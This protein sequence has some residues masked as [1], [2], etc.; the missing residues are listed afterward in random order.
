[1][2]A[3]RVVLLK[4]LQPSQCPLGMLER[5]E[6]NADSDW[7][8]DPVHAQSLVQTLHNAFGAHDV[9]Q[10]CYYGRVDV[11]RVSYRCT[12]HQQMLE[13]CVTN[14]LVD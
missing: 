4:H 2:L 12:P 6:A 7:T 8:F 10:R 5:R 9:P 14:R 1:M 3:G 11:C 13:L